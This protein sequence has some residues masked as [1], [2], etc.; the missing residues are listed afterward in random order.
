MAT[1][2]TMEERETISEMQAAG[3]SPAPTALALGRHRSTV[4]RELSRNQ[5]PHGYR[6]VQAHQMALQRR[7]QR[8][9]AR[10][11]DRPETREQVLEH[12]VQYCSPEQIAGRSTLEANSP[13]VPRQTIYRWI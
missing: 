11:M 5:A 12:L 3:E 8:P 2:L 9:L 4:Y 7:K 10:K 1:Q 13:L 6:A